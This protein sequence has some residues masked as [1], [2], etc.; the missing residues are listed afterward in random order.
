MVRT[1]AALA[2]ALV[3]AGMLA[4]TTADLRAGVPAF[5][6]ESGTPAAPAADLYRAGVLATALGV[7]A[8]GLALHRWGRGAAGN[9]NPAGRPAASLGA[10][11]LLLLAA[12]AAATSALVHCSPGCP[13]PPYQRATPAD[14]VHAAASIAALGL[15]AL[16]MVLLAALAPDRTLRRRCVGAA[17]LAVPVLLVAASCL[18]FV[19]RSTFTGLAE[20]AG[21]AAV[22]AWLLI[23]AVRL[24]G[25]PDVKRSGP[26][27][28]AGGGR[29]VGS[30]GTAAGT[31]KLV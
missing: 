4:M 29:G 10:A 19:G 6:S 21:L 28:G 24:V 5:V 27:P 17:V 1:A 11:A 7:A 3:A 13:L 31:R 12:P 20:R 30:S 2:A 25:H 15:L 18:A 9:A 14:L 22:A 23:V 16:A 8:L 26:R